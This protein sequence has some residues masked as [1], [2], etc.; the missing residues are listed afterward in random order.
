MS[1]D[2]GPAVIGPAA[3]LLPD[4]LEPL[5][6]EARAE[7]IHI[8]DR[9]VTNWRDQTERYDRPGELLL[10]AVSGSGRPVGVGGLTVCPTVAGALRVRRFYVSP[11]WRRRGLAR[12][13]AARVLDGAVLHTELVTCNAGASDAA[14]PFWESLG[15]EP[16]DLPGIT[17]QLRR[18]GP[19]TG[20]TI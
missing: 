20:P 3:E 19:R 14:V 15:F 18:A 11:D 10:A 1:A 9:V 13:L 6:A 7:G 16:V 12:D 8:V 17:H 2:D 4:G 5:A